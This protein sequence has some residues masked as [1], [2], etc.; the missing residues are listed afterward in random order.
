[1]LLLV[2]QTAKLTCLLLTAFCPHAQKALTAASPAAVVHALMGIPEA[3]LSE[4]QAQA[5]RML[6]SMQ[7]ILTSTA[8]DLMCCA[9]LNRKQC[10]RPSSLE[11]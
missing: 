9:D 4:T 3:H 11:A 1:M 7:D 8:D 6:G 5:L 10:A 2:G